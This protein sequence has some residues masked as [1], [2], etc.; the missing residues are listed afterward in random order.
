MTLVYHKTGVAPEGNNNCEPI[1]TISSPAKSHTGFISSFFSSN[2]YVSS[3]LK[4][5]VIVMIF[6]LL[7]T[8]FQQHQKE[9]NL[10]NQ[11]IEKPKINDIYLLDFRLFNESLRPK[12]R[13]RIAKIFDITGDVITLR[14]GDLLFPSKH[15]ATDSIRFGQLSYKEYFQPERFD[16][17]HE[18]IATLRVEG[19]IYLA[20]R[21][22]QNKV[23]GNYVSPSKPA[24]NSRFFIKGK[25]EY[26]SGVA[27]FEDQYDELGLAKA[28]E[29][30]TQSAKLGF[31]EGQIRLAEMY[32]SGI[33]TDQ[34]IN[35]T[36]FWLEQAAL[37]SNKRAILKYG[38]VCKQLE[39]CSIVDFYRMLI[40]NGVNLKVRNVDVKLSSSLS[41]LK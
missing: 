2:S 9:Q 29:H 8:Q 13:Y 5:L 25:K 38:I 26:L 19:A 17:S 18:E 10:T 37:Q 24:F 33:E 23:F 30:F 3:C 11:I 39:S 6:F 32:L 36:L 15:K 28:F 31:P 41:S 22:F 4:F 16:F 1:L 14:Y 27:Y 35:L 40:E 7:W 21:P 12:E 34:N 20:K